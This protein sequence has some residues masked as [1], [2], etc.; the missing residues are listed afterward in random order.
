MPRTRR[1]LAEAR[2]EEDE[3]HPRVGDDVA[4]GV[5]AVVATAVGDDERALVPHDH[6]AGSVPARRLVE[7]SVTD[8]G[9][10]DEGRRLDDPGLARRDGRGLLGEAV[11]RRRRGVDL[12]QALEGGDRVVVVT[13]VTVVLCV[14]VGIHPTTVC[15]PPP[16]AQALTSPEHGPTTSTL[17]GIAG[18]LDKGF[19]GSC[20]S[21]ASL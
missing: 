4:Q 1:L 20:T 17:T 9:H 15:R 18:W 10:D 11:G 12:E 14:L 5:E 7:A 2:H 6:E 16:H 21:R 13:V 19:L 8:G 3:T